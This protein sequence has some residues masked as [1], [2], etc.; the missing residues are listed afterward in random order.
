MRHFLQ[1]AK[2]YSND[3]YW[4]VKSAALGFDSVKNVNFLIL[5]RYLVQSVPILQ[6]N[7]NEVHTCAVFTHCA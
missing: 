5:Q 6:E 7:K 2:W 1:M 3:L 4:D